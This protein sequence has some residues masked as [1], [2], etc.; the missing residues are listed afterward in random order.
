M[1]RL[2]RLLDGCFAW[3]VAARRSALVLAVACAVAAC[4]GGGGGGDSGAATGGAVAVASVGLS[5]AS[6]TL[7]AGG[8]YT[9]TASL[10]DASGQALSGR[11]VSWASSN[12]AVASVSGTG[13]VTA[14][15]AGS[16][17]ITATVEGKSASATVTVVGSGG[18]AAVV[19]LDAGSVGGSVRDV[20]GVNK[21]PT[22]SAQTPGSSW[23]GTGLYQAFGVSQVRLHDAGVD[24][25]STYTAASKLNVG[26]SPAQTVSGCTL[27]GSGSVPHFKWTP[28]SSADADLNNPDNYDFTEVDAAINAALATG[29]KVYLRLGESYNGPNDTDDPVAWAKVA[30]NIYRHVI[31][32]FKPTSGIAVDPVFVEVHNEPDGGFWRG[33]QT[34]FN[35]LF[36]E[37]ASR[38]RAAASA[39]GRS[40]KLGGA[41]F[42]RSV[43]T[44]STKAGN[45]A[46]NFIANVGAS[47]LDFYSAHLYDSCSTATLGSSATFLRNLR[48][49]VN[50]QGGSGK[51]LHITEWNIGLGNQCGNAQYAEPRMLSYTSGV[52]T[53]MQDP[54]QAIEAAHFYAG[55][56][57]MA[58]F[59]F[60]SVSNAVRINPSAWAFWAHRKL[61]GGS[62]LSTQ[63]CPG[64]ASCV[65]G[66]AADTAPVVALAAQ[67]G[68]GSSLVRR[69]VVTNDSASAVTYT[70]QLSNLTDSSTLNAVVYTPPGAAQDV[71]A[72][73][74][75]VTPDSAALNSLLASPGQQ[76]RSVLDV[77]GGQLQLTLTVPAYGLQVVEL[78]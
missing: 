1:T 17:T 25:C 65:A 59:D 8:S 2:D 24:L 3:P 35:T 21:R 27:S 36:T 45:P 12:P 50:S 62:L 48:A 28:T 39:A 72:K 47:T 6:N 14:L 4:T 53:L 78:K 31:G 43:L 70:L 10:G 73:G 68:A 67:S 74:N 42:T 49:L 15:A 57:I 40:V 38:V 20:L 7:D 33:S 46:N 13:A 61:Y 77:K 44:S 69:A 58:L 37:T 23:D 63:V 52:L 19:K 76:T 22:A 5:P 75:P 66:Y 60:T 64:G 55:M 51:P 32:V 30:T 26:V 54:A 9:L 34:T 18:A 11:S 29:A 16:A 56:P 71:S 41:G